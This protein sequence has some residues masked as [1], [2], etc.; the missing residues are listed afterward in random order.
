MIHKQ[1]LEKKNKLNRYVKSSPFTRFA[2]KLTFVIG[3]VQLIAFNQVLG[4]WPH[5]FYY[6][7]HAFFVFSMIFGKWVYYKTIGLHYYMIDFCY[8]TNALVIYYLHYEPK[9]DI[10]FKI[11]FLCANGPLAVSTAAFSNKMIFHSMQELSSLVVHMMPSIAMWN[12]KWYT[13]E[14]EK[15]LPPEERRF[16]ELDHTFDVYTL[17]VYPLAY[18]MAWLIIYAILNFI[19]LQ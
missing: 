1:F 3:V 11:C 6:T 5:S 12:L 4:R 16:L 17:V 10:L 18:Y 14:Y 7:Y 2:D 19:L 15:T 13:M 8:I 9:N